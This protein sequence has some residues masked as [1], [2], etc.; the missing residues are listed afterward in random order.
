MLT[1]GRMRVRLIL[2]AGIL[3]LVSSTALPQIEKVGRVCGQ[4]ICLE[5]WPK[6]EPVKGWHHEDGASFANRANVQVPDGFTFSNAE[7]VIYARALYKPRNPET[8]SLEVLIQ[9]DRAEFLKEDSSIEVTKVS[10][11]KTKDGKP[12]ETY[13]FFPKSKGNW[14]EVSYGEEGDF[15]LIFTISSRSHA[16]F[17]ASLPV[18][19]QYIARYKE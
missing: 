6:L 12:L 1:K 14:E 11:L 17:L 19:E 15:Y 7:T 8:T 13:T 2:L 3:L 10:P 4:G 18:Y 16:G 9:D 5:W